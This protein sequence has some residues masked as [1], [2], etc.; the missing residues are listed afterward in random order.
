VFL[1]IQLVLSLVKLGLELFMLSL[2]ESLLDKLTGLAAIVA[3]KP[4]G[5]NPSLTIRGH[6]DFNGL[7]AAP[8]I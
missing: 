7:Q 5:L 2:T 8:P 4:L 6:D 1:S 3:N